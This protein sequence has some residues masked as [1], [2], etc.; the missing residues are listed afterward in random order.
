[1]NLPRVLYNK[2]FLKLW[3]AQIAS[4]FALNILN[5]VLLIK[6]YEATTS[7]TPVSLLLLAFGVP[8]LL[9]GYLAGSYVDSVDTKSVLII[10][11]IIRALVIL[12]LFFLPAS[13]A[14]YYIVALIISLA[15]QFFIPAEGSLL[16]KLVPENQLLE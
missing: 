14:G 8:G 7:N 13:L 4:Q 10:T 3:I 2:E 11:N 6:V 15:S 16:P 12:L 1:M 5:F 9:L